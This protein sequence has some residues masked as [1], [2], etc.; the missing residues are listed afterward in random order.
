[1]RDL[2][3]SDIEGFDNGIIFIRVYYISLDSENTTN[4]YLL[5]VARHIYTFKVIFKLEYMRFT[6]FSYT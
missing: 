1:M 6:T 4:P 5:K 2:R 3:I